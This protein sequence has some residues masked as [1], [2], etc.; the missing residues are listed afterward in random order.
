MAFSRI[1]S[2]LSNRLSEGPFT[3]DEPNLPSGGHSGYRPED[4]RAQSRRA[5]T[6]QRFPQQAGGNRPIGYS[7]S[8]TVPQQ[9]VG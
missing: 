8:L 5:R 6:Q 7:G 1:F 2:S 9:T 4:F 3:T